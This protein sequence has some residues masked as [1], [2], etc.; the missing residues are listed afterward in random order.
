[1]KKALLIAT[2]LMAINLPVNAAQV[3]QFN[4]ADQADQAKVSQQDQP[5]QTETNVCIRRVS[6]WYCF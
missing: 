6:G 5:I 2:G 3:A 4:G 1:V